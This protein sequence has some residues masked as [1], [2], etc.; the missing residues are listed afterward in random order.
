MS[1]ETSFG[2]PDSPSRVWRSRQYPPATLTA[3]MFARYLA[4]PRLVHLLCIGSLINRA[5][6]FV[7]IF[8]SI[9]ASEQ[10]G[11]GVTFATACIG[12]LG[13]GA[14]AGSVIGGHLADRIGR[15]PV[16]LFALFGG[17][18]MLLLMSGFTNRWFF[19]VSVG[20]FSLLAHLYRPAASAMIADLV[21]I[22]SRP[23][24]F[25]L[26][27]IS[28]NLGFAIAAPVGGFLAAYSF[29]WL[30]WLDA[31]SLA[32]LATIIACLIPETRNADVPSVG[33]HET[34]ESKSIERA[35]ALRMLMDHTF[36]LF[37]LSTLLIMLVFVQGFSTLPIYMKQIGMTNAEF[38]ALISI[39]GILIVIL[40]LPL[41][42]WLSRF[43]AMSV[44]IVG[45]LLIALGFGINALGP[46]VGIVGLGI[47]SWTLGEILQAPFKQS[48]VSDL[49][50]DDLRAS[51][52]GLFS[53]CYAAALTLGAPMGGELL[54]RFGP[55]T[56]WSV[57]AC[58]A[59]TAV[60]L[61]ALIYKSIT[62]RL[63]SAIPDA[64]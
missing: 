54:N 36:L 15:K 45:G 39:N 3:P 5:G 23:L 27:Y 2:E 47:C 11:L 21:T 52:M 37:C 56:L 44:I 19:M 6:S 60:V 1:F 10:L 50:P 32:C 7:V 22:E 8:L 62:R 29:T 14:M 53:M 43:Q 51:Y 18:A 4:L 58:I 35:G 42:Q 64:L 12:V 31:A 24:A 59:C 16:M 25:A 63:V 30:F 26:L 40:Q 33:K 9:Y 28:V 13:G 48:V 55:S 46:G 38:G 57:V 34:T 41:T 20:L 61:Y 17:A 49:A